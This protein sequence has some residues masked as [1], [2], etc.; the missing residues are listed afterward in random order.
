MAV[1]AWKHVFGITDSTF[2]KLPA[3][4]WADIDICFRLDNDLLESVWARTNLKQVRQVN[5]SNGVYWT[6]FNSDKLRFG[7]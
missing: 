6:R 7:F 5:F 3:I 1:P 2:T 4:K